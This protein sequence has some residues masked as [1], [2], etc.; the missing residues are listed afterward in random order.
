M[1]FDHT[2]AATCSVR[3]V[4]RLE[5]HPMIAA[6]YL[7]KWPAIIPL[8]LGLFHGDVLRGVAVFGYPPRETFKRYGGL[9]WELARLWVDDVMPPNTE[10]W[11]LARCVRYIRQHFQAVIGLVSYADPS[12]GHIGTI[13]KAANW[14]A[15][16][17]TGDNR[18][19]GGPRTDYFVDGKKYSRAAH[20]PEGSEIVRVARVSKKRFYLRLKSTRRGKFE[21]RKSRQ[22]PEMPTVRPQRNGQQHPGQHQPCDAVCQPSAGFGVSGGMDSGE[23][24]SGRGCEAAVSTDTGITRAVGATV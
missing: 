9:V 3:S 24:V 22:V 5:A 18:S 21:A 11:F 1:R 15:D 23:A 12:A 2:L 17:M 13:Y 20:I 6:H 8:S 4:T 19:V 7:Q 16:G 10:T 14:Q